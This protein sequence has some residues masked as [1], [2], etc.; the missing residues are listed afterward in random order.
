MK[1]YDKATVG[2]KGERI[3][4]RFLRRQGYRIVARNKHYGKN[5]LDLIAKNKDFLVF[6]EVKTRSFADGE[7]FTR[8]AEAVDL[9]K[10]RRTA[11][12][13]RAHLR[14]HPTA[15]CPRFDVIEVYLARKRRLPVMRINHIPDAFSVSGHVRH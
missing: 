6:V 8:P 2:K 13:A 1:K 3:A 11:E 5:E 15:H 9:A 7:Q 12:A 10:R 14:E 4:A